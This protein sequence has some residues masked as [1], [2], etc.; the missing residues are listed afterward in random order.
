MSALRRSCRAYRRRHP[1]DP[2]PPT[3]RGAFV[4]NITRRNDHI[5]SVAPVSLSQ[6]RHEPNTQFRGRVVTVGACQPYPRAPILRDDQN[7][8]RRLTLPARDHSAG[9][10][11]ISSVHA[12]LSRHGRSAGCARNHL[13]LLR[14]CGAGST[15]LVRRSLPVRANVDQGPPQLGI[16]RGLSQDRWTRGLSLARRGQRR[17]A[18]VVVQ[19]KRSKAEALKLHGPKVQSHKQL[20][21]L[22]WL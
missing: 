4:E 3:L 16:G 20:I 12:R 10:L 6:S 13:V 1:P 7:Q 15:T 17:G 2:N 8:L 18:D 11:A 9:D 14:P 21:L 19:T 5:K 22:I